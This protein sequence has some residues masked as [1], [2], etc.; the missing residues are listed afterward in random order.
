MGDFCYYQQSKNVH[1][2]DIDYPNHSYQDLKEYL[3][4]TLGKKESI[5][6]LNMIILGNTA[7]S[8]GQLVIIKKENEVI[9]IKQNYKHTLIKKRVMDK[10][11]YLEYFFKYDN[12]SGKFTFKVTCNKS[13][14]ISNV[15]DANHMETLVS[16]IEEINSFDIFPYLNIC[17][18]DI[19]IINGHKGNLE[20]SN[21]EISIYSSRSYNQDLNSLVCYQFI[22]VRN[23]T[24]EVVGNIKF[25]FNIT[26]ISYAI[27]PS[28]QGHHYAG[29]ALNLLIELIKNNIYF[30]EDNLYVR[31]YEDN[32]ASLKTAEFCHLELVN[33]RRGVQ[34]YVVNPQKVL[35]AK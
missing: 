7:Y 2:I 17:E 33:A 22:I 21:D 18:K 23:D 26:N 20:I 15:T 1:L 14:I 16:L 3:E 4:N 28:H 29:K 9:N 12:L 30:Q 32:I 24:R 19:C 8:E 31:I 11:D 35:T 25:D 10:N 27:K 13:G 5:N 6:L 34:E